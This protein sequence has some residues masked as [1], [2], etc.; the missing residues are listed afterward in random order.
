MRVFDPARGVDDYL[1]D[2][3]QLSPFVPPLCIR[4]PLTGVIRPRNFALLLF[5]REPQ[6]RVAG[7]FVLFSIYPGVDRSEPHAERHEVAGSLLVQINRLIELLNV[8]SYTAFDKTDE[9]TPNALKYPRRALHEAMINALVHRDY[10]S[11]DPI[12]ITVFA[13][14]IEIVSPGGLVAGVT[15]D[16]LRAGSRHSPTRILSTSASSSCTPRFIACLP[17]PTP[18]SGSFARTKTS[19]IRSPRS[20]WF[21]SVTPCWPF[22]LRLRSTGTSHRCCCSELRMGDS[23][24]V[25]RERS[26]SACSR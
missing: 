3:R 17:T 12:R 25:R 5:G 6:A 24:S 11:V 14:R 7:S 22:Q 21:T 16:E 1:S 4:E 19:S 2:T 15:L 26:R 9:S 10:E 18:S 23:R 13:D 20:H 8:Q